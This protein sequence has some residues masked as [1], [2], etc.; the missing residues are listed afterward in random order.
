MSSD[1]T[2]TAGT[3]FAWDVFISHASE[4]K[5]QVAR[6]LSTLLREA[7]LR[8]WYDEDVL[9]LGD[10]LNESIALGLRRSRYSLVILSPNFIR[11][12][13][14]TQYELNGL[15]SL[16]DA[17]E[18]RVLP[19]THDLTQQEV[20]TFNPT[21]ADRVSISTAAGLGAV[22]K[23][24]LQLFPGVPA[25][26]NAP[27]AA[28]TPSALRQRLISTSQALYALL[29]DLEEFGIAISGV[30]LSEYRFSHRHLIDALAAGSD[31]SLHFAERHIARAIEDVFKLT[32]VQLSQKLT[33]LH[34]SEAGLLP[35]D[36]QTL[37]AAQ[38]KLAGYVESVV[39]IRS[40]RQSI[41]PA[42]I[43][44]TAAEAAH[45]LSLLGNVRPESTREGAPSTLLTRALE[46]AKM[47]SN[48]L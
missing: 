40:G 23:A 45:V 22:C 31:E 36:R 18:R 3:E 27:L 39:A 46:A 43:A 16:E 10:S 38:R 17:G 13:K 21:L 2:S 48:F 9:R 8:V 33:D 5:E 41:S 26:G 1:T 6:P 19:V 32:V 30:V 28:D 20:G 29:S 25:T 44:A 7:G 12:K 47:L 11:M 42:K 14:W 35:A 4:D 37:L 15:F 34:V 24:V